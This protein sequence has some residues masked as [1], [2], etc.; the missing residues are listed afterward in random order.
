M[1][2]TLRSPSPA[3]YDTIAAWIPDGDACRRWAGPKVPFPFAAADLPTLLPV[4][5]GGSY[6]LVGDR[7]APLG[8][9]QYWPRPGN[10]IHLLRIIVSPE[11]RGKGLGREL[12]RQLIGRALAASPAHALTLN[13]YRE[14]GPAVALYEGLGFTVDAE[15]SN[16][17]ALFMIKRVP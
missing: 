5:G 13:V 9:G 6:C 4:P 11:S 8:F 10:T 15:K 1:N 7:D 16:E 14:N 17:N 12:C 2:V 3:D